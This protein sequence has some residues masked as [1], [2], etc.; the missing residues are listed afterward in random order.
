MSTKVSCVGVAAEAAA[1]KARER[2]RTRRRGRGGGER[3]KGEWRVV[4][5]S[6]HGTLSEYEEYV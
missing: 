3:K 6:V 5:G 2:A 4:V 1:V